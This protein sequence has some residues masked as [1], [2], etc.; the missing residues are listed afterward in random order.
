[1]N[2]TASTSLSLRDPWAM[3]PSLGNL[4]AYVSA[5]NRLPMLTQAQELGFGIMFCRYNVCNTPIKF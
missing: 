1:M 4:D 2:A 3:V 5:V